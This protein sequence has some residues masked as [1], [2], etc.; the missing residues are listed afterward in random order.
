MSKRP[1]EFVHTCDDGKGNRDIWLNGR[2]LKYVVFAD[3]RRG[4]VRV[5]RYP[6]RL[7]KYRKRVLQVTL[8][9]RVEVK[10]RPLSD[11]E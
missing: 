10:M 4:K 5:D 11:V 3:V 9:G 1:S 2:L 8:R 6:L 7:D